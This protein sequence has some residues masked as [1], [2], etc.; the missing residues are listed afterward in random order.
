[1]VGSVDR[2]A[3]EVVARR[4]A[5]DTVLSA[6]NIAAPPRSHQR[7]ENGSKRESPKER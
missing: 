4:H 3:C 2:R 1:M 6:P 7:Q 5:A